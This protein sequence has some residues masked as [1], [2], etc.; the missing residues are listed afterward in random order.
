MRFRWALPIVLLLIVATAVPA[1]AAV[2]RVDLQRAADE[3]AAA[4]QQAAEIEE[5]Y[6][7]AL[8][9]EA[10]LDDL[11]LELI[12]SAEA[13]RLAQ[14]SARRAATDRVDELYMR[15][16][17]GSGADLMAV[18]GLSNGWVRLVYAGA[19]ADLDREAI[20]TFE[21]TRRDLLRLQELLDV[22]VAEQKD[23]SL[24]LEGSA[25]EAAARLVEA[26]A[27]YRR[28]RA[29]WEW[30]EEQRRLAEEAAAAAAAAAAATPEEDATGPAPQEPSGSSTPPATT[31]TTVAAAPPAT[32]AAPEPVSGGPFPAPVERWRSLVAKY[33][34]ADMVDDALSVMACESFGDPNLTNS[35]S[36]AAGLF[37]HLQKYWPE[38]AAGAG[39]PGASPY[40]GEANI[41]A[42]WWLV[43]RSLDLGF[44]AWHFWT[45]KP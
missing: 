6:R 39:F 1:Q 29:E 33:F 34:P 32:A 18:G 11:L 30:Q 22:A 3:L 17:T 16:G 26:E 44:S 12:G 2:D 5:E 13:A 20:L 35:Y 38:R 31:S 24:Q 15:A 4:R 42:T 25:A 41:A 43:S 9:E 8:R 21:A 36:G 45:C 23:L 37:Q 27:E 19:V 7:A 40:D 10:A 14:E 28:V